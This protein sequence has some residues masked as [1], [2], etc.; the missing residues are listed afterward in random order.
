[1][2]K[3]GHEN[4]EKTKNGEKGQKLVKIVNE[5]S[6][7]DI[8]AMRGVI[9]SPCEHCDCVRI[10]VLDLWCHLSWLSGRDKHFIIF[11]INIPGFFF[12]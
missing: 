5:D 3:L 9:N 7:D 8:L 2:Q 1:M 4:G 10:P 6:S 11:T 12:F